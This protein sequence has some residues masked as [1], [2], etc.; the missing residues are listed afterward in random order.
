[1]VHWDDVDGYR[2]EAGHIAGTWFDL[3]TAAGTL[4]AGLKRIEVDAGK[5]STPAH[6]EGAE[7]EIFY[8]L[9]G[10]GLSWQDGSAYQV[11]AGDCLVHLPGGEAHTLRAGPEGLDVLAFGQRL[12]HGNTVL[13]RAK[14]AWMSPAFV[15]AVPIGE[16]HPY[17]R[18][19]AAGEPEVGELMERPP[20]IA[21]VTD[22]IRHEIRPGAFELD[23]GRRVGS[24]R[25]A[26]SR[27][28][29]EP[30]KDGYPPHCH[31]AEEE[32]FVILEGSGALLLGDEEVAVR[33]GHVL[34][35]P[36]GTRIAHSLRAGEEGMT[37]LAYGT[38]EPNDVAYYPRS[39]K[40]S[41][42]GVGVIARLESL[43]YWDGE[44]ID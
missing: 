22:G 23:L 16:D 2:R 44:P 28:T 26:L 37:Y 6:T 5:W 34:G 32:I 21:N 25:T 18:E 17:K 31:S 35:R 7:E 33:P 10:S 12:D 43:D 29:L 4:N 30:G 41:F 11:G 13:P 20:G 38:R 14:V 27:V 3:G 8:V 19:A 1:V 9:R 40:I 39:N 24:A 15:E 36:P 42:R